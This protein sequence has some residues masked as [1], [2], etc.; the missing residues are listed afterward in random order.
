[1]GM[2]NKIVILGILA[3]ALI[4]FTAAA[5]AS[6]ATIGDV[7]LTLDSFTRNGNY[8]GLPV[9]EGG[10][11]SR[12]GYEY[13]F[14]PDGTYTL[15]CHATNDGTAP[16]IA[17]VE[18]YS[19]N[20]AYNTWIWGATVPAGGRFD[21]TMTMP[22]TGDMEFRCRLSVGGNTEYLFDYGDDLDITEPEDMTRHTIDQGSM[23]DGVAVYKDG[24]LAYTGLPQYSIGLY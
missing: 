20:P 14:V 1:M 16:T 8:M 4:A 5:S 21:Y 10:D 3:I 19:G 15:T 24:K 7:T 17:A 22:N 12:Y 2:R 11:M 6:S 23:S 18:F 9:L 13:T